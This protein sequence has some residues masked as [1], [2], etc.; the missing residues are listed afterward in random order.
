VIQF[1]LNIAP[2]RRRLQDNSSPPR[3][4]PPTPDE[5]RHEAREI[6]AR[7]TVDEVRAAMT[8][9]AASP[10]VHDLLDKATS[11]IW[12]EVVSNAGECSSRGTTGYG[13]G[14][15]GRGGGC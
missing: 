9:D 15:S 8:I 13:R 12:L 7:T 5:M 1:L 14:R 11:E 4:A 3:P 6:A 2:G 10:E